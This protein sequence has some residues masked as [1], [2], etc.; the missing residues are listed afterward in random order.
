MKLN[1]LSPAPGSKKTRKRVG[2]GLGSG[3]GKTAGRGQ[4]GQ[5]S[6]SGHSQGAGWEGGRS[7]LIMR[8]PKRGFTRVKEPLQLVNLR[9]LNAFAAG[10]SIDAAKL[11]ASG[12]VRRVDHRVKLLA[13]G[14]LEVKGL[15]ITVDAASKGALAAVEAAGGKVVLTSTGEG[16]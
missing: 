9:D 11:V 5:T 10:E 16:A 12:L 15:T 8:L 13:D 3:R 14:E 6:R 2:R 4:K 7:R 1:E